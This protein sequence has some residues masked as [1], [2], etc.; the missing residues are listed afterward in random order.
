VVGG[1]YAGLETFASIKV[2]SSRAVVFPQG[3]SQS[4]G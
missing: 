1:G 3:R 4:Y 2:W